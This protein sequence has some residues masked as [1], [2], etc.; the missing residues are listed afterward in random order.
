MAACPE[1]PRQWFPRHWH[2]PRRAGTKLQPSTVSLSQG[3]V[4]GQAG[5][6][7]LGKVWSASLVDLGGFLPVDLCGEG[8]AW[9][10]GEALVSWSWGDAITPGSASPQNMDRVSVS[11]WAQEGPG[12]PC[13][14]L[15]EP[16]T[17]TMLTLSLL[18]ATLVVTGRGS[19]DP[20]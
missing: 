1:P 16:S 4:L 14:L 5:Q 13:H 20:A 3:L 9:A 6:E 10:G 17:P 11:A 18:S 15:W 2:G 8:P 7:V 19:A 12:L